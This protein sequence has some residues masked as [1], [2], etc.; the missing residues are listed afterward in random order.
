MF[1]NL[2]PVVRALLLVNFIVYALQRFTGYGAILLEHFA[3]WPIDP[4]GDA[5]RAGVPPFEPWQLLT[6]AFLHD[7]ENWM[8]IIGNMLAVYMFGPDTELVLG[9]KRFG[10]YYIV[11]VIGAA[12]TQLAVMHASASAP[13]LTVG[14]SGGIFGILL[15]F[16]MSFPQRKVIMLFLPIPMPAWLFVTLYGLYEF[17]YGLLGGGDGV[18]HF[19]HLGGL[20]TGAAMIL[21]W[22]ARASGPK[23][24]IHR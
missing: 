24:P 1:R 17:G 7:P 4:I 15:L 19:A 16:G 5:Q 13:Y 14:A 6:Y 22:R 2:T 3:L 18:A 8:H 9:S 10:F 20:A 23:A 12:V 21:Y 11:C